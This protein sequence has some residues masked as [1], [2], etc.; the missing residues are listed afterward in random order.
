MIYYVIFYLTAIYF[1]YNIFICIYIYIC[2]YGTY[3]SWSSP[4]WKTRQ[5]HWK[6]KWLHVRTLSWRHTSKELPIPL[7]KSFFSEHWM[8]GGM[9]AVWVLQKN[10]FHNA[11]MGT[12]C[13]W[14]FLLWPIG[15]PSRLLKKLKGL[16]GQAKSLP[17]PHLM[18]QGPVSFNVYLRAIESLC[19]ERR[20]K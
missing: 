15:L 17:K 8:F 10:D 16:F 6:P 13:I 19:L 3:S 11:I 9:G 14:N 1:T 4:G 5:L 18:S 2:I 12:T 20:I 7:G